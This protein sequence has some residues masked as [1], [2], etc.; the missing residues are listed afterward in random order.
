[1]G[2]LDIER[3]VPL[4][5]LTTLGLGGRARYYVRAVGEETV[6]DALRWASERSQPLAI[7]GGG[8]NVIVPDEGYAGLVVHVVMDRLEAE[9]GGVLRVEAGVP[10]ERVV[11]VS[12][13]RGWAGLE[14]LTGI[15]GLTGATPIQNVGAYGQEV[16][17]VIE[18]VHV[19][20]RDTLEREA[21][22]PAACDFGYR[23][24]VFKREPGRFVV[25]AVD[26]RLRPGGAPSVRYAELAQRLGANA[27]L[28]DVRRTVLA[29]RRRKSMV[30]DPGD[31]N[32]RSV[33][34]FF[35]NPVISSGEAD[36]VVAD[37]L[38]KGWVSRASD[39]PRYPVEDGQVKLAAAWLIE[40]SGIEKG[41]RR[42]AFGVS[43][44]HA[45]ALVHHGGGSTKAL[46]TFAD[47]IAQRVYDHFGIELQRE[48]RLLE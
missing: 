24:S 2:E 33:G 7:L 32:R 5:P 18:R 44:R 45:L 35:L 26:F 1:M 10:W 14:C 9:E 21:L 11:D 41:T 8:S 20:R 31:P 19:L 23:D 4:A 28:D 3:D 15:P 40:K 6:V 27:T 29:L 48:P 34:S 37:A 13:G 46:L 17:D 30:L 42:G 39:V 16:A 38:R 25:T 22:A 36:R 47:E 43:T 12:L